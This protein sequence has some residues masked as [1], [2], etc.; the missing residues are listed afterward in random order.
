MRV[1]PNGKLGRPRS[2]R[3]ELE[4]S[5]AVGALSVARDGRRPPT[6]HVAIAGDDAIQYTRSKFPES[7][8]FGVPVTVPAEGASG[9]AVAVPFS[10]HGLV[11][12]VEAGTVRANWF[13]GGANTTCR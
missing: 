11:A 1:T 13:T 5:G 9:L 7:C 3:K 8:P 2:V 6:V 12:W 4:G 10:T